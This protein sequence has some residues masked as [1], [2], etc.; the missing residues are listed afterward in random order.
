MSQGNEH[1]SNAFLKL[2]VPP[3]ALLPRTRDAPQ[4]PLRYKCG[5]NAP[6]WKPSLKCSA[7]KPAATVSSLLRD[8]WTSNSALM[9][10]FWACVSLLVIISATCWFVHLSNYL[11]VV[12]GITTKLCTRGYLCSKLLALHIRFRAR[13]A[14][15]LQGVASS[16]HL[17]TSAAGACCRL[18]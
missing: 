15:L 12:I 17:L 1:S 2:R 8:L 5:T 6:T 4:Q 9:F 7:V 11:H 13:R 10:A 14:R 3:K 18:A 16:M